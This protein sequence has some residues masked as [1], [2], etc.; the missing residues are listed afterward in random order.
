MLNANLLEEN[1]ELKKQLHELRKMEAGWFGKNKNIV[2]K[3][4]IVK[5]NHYLDEKEKI[6]SEVTNMRQRC[7]ML[8]KERLDLINKLKALEA[9]LA[10]LN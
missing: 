3:E 10:G 7:L 4:V 1:A 8:E 2:K 9:K 5:N 6:T